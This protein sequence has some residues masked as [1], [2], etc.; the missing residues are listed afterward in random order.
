MLIPS[1][2]TFSEMKPHQNGLPGPTGANQGL[3]GD[4]THTDL[5]QY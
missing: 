5:D 2:S 1:G 4:F 3:T